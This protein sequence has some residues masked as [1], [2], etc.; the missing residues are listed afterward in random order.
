MAEKDGIN[1]SLTAA[2]KVK[3]SGN[4]AMLYKWQPMIKEYKPELI[5]SLKEKT[6]EFESLYEYLAPLHGWIELDRQAW[7]SDLER[8]PDETMNCLRALKSAWNNGR[9]GCPTSED[10]ARLKH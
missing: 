8:C 1:L 9:Y 10:W 7:A 4:E 3:A 2:G 6:K 5:K